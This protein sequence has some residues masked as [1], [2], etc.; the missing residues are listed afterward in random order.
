MLMMNI[1]WPVDT[2]VVTTVGTRG[3]WSQLNNFKLCSYEF[4]SST[5]HPCLSSSYFITA[6]SNAR[7]CAVTEEVRAERGTR[8]VTQLDPGSAG[9]QTCGVTLP[10]I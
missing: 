6:Q 7:P 4:L 5:I 9:V 8:R 10:P 1:Q 3:G 2:S